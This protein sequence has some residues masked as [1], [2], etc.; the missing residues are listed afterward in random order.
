[1]LGLNLT[2]IESRPIPDRKFEHYFE[3]F[4]YLDFIGSVRDD[5]VLDLICA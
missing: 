1:M 5:K 3:Y 4:F 2:K